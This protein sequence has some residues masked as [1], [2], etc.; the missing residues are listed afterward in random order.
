MGCFNK[1]GFISGL[2]IHA[3]D[4]TVLVFMKKSK[5]SDSKLGG[6]T[7]STDWFEPAFL[8]IFGD[9]DDYGR[10]ENVVNNPATKFIEKFFG[11]KIDSIIEI[12]DDSAV[13]RGSDGKLKAVYKDFTFG[14]EHRKVYDFMSS[15]KINSYTESYITP[16]WLEKMGFVKQDEESGDERFKQIW[17]NSTIPTEYEVHS[18]G[19]WSHLMKNGKEDRN[20]SVYHPSQLEE[21]LTTVSKGTYKSNLTQEDKE[22]CQLD[23][24]VQLSKQ[25][26]LDHK[27]E[28]EEA[29]DDTEK[30]FRVKLSLFGGGRESYKGQDTIGSWL[31]KALLDGKQTCDYSRNLGEVVD[32]LDSKLLAD[33]ARFNCTVSRLNAKYCPSNYGS[34]DQDHKLHYDILKVYRGVIVDK[35]ME[36]EDDDNELLIGIK[37]DIKSDDREEGLVKIMN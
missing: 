3:G 14:L 5:Y 37:A 25:L 9:Y 18:D 8:P 6:V 33:F 12:I 24:A 23:L 35:I 7:Y 26:R 28:I 20:Q 36:Y 1:I 27:K 17:R 19:T 34:Q 10:I 16:Y 11:D 13:G 4:A 2:P 31:S 32:E 29:G 22:T 15:R 30:A 21:A